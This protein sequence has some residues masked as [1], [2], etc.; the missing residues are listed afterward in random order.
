M[1]LSIILLKLIT[2]FKALYIEE[3]GDNLTW[4]L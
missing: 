4:L 2:V 3:S 1:P